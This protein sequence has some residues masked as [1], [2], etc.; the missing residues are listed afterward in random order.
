MKTNVSDIR[1]GLLYKQFHTSC[2]KKDGKFFTLTL[3]TDGVSVVKTS[4]FSI[5]PILCSINE[6]PVIERLKNII[7]AGLWFGSAKPTFSTFFSPF[8]TETNKLRSSGFKLITYSGTPFKLYATVL[9]CT[10]DSVARCML[11]NVKQFNGNFG[12]DWCLIKGSRE[13]KGKGSVHVYIPI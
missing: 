11:Q 8:T 4:L 10:C 2:V 7:L 9:L 3:N 12:C 6:L 1:D 5:W 13:T